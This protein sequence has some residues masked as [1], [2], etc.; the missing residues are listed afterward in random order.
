MIIKIVN[1]IINL[2]DLIPTFFV[3]EIYSHMI[4]EL[5]LLSSIIQ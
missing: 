2:N 5:A 1:N 4:E 3:F